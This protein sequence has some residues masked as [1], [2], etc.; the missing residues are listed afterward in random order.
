MISNQYD[1]AY[2]SYQEKHQW[3][4]FSF[5]KVAFSILFALLVARMID[6]T[7][8]QRVFLTSEGN[9]YSQKLASSQQDRLEIVDTNGQ[10]L[11]INVAAKTIWIDPAVIQWTDRQRKQVA[12]LLKI[13][14]E[15]LAQKSRQAGK[16]FV[17]LKRKVNPEVAKALTQLK[18]KG[19][20]ADNDNRRYYTS[21]YEFA[22]LLGRTGIEGSGLE[23]IEFGLNE[24]LAQEK[25]D[26]Y[27][28]VDRFGRMIMKSDAPLNGQNIALAI[29]ARF[30]KTAYEL[31]KDAVLAHEADY[32]SMV[33][34]NP[35]TGEVVAMA[36]FPT[37]NPNESTLAY[38]QNSNNRAVTDLF[39]PGSVIKPIILSAVMEHHPIDLEQ[40]INVEKGKWNLNGHLIKDVSVGH[41]QLSVKD[42]IKRSSNIG[43]SKLALSV[44]FESILNSLDRFGFGQ[45]LTN[46]Y[47]G[48][49]AGNLP[50]LS[51]Q[52]QIGV[53][54][55]SYGYGIAVNQLQLTH[56]YSIIANDGKD[57]GVHFLKQSHGINS[58][59]Q[60][61]SKEISEQVR[62]TLAAAAEH[63]G[64]AK[65]ASVPGIKIGGKTG[66]TIINQD[67]ANGYEALFAGIVPIDNPKWVISVMIHR[68]RVNGYYGGLVAA[69][70]FS[71]MVKKVFFMPE[72][73]KS[74][75]NSQL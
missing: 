44:P 29:D 30:Q 69:P 23:G 9:K 57:A 55:L 12:V 59:E 68:P 24:K 18:I 10:K 71:K 34:M 16:R 40:M 17:Y 28:E 43:M 5:M 13:S 6:L 46:I 8:Y 26:G 51:E 25:T 4:R 53:A 63:D 2:C 49:K 19:L 61:I 11:A 36:Q 35:K 54:G 39:E 37:V 20:H 58:Q 27:F 65:R 70:I 56:A 14:E 52:D 62:K 75:M 3:N 50:I 32:G 21:G 15:S 41:D 42:I 22:N 1:T 60:V 7:C 72:T 38:D 45:K 74:E 33:V 73:G 31:L 66:T 48:V 64:T 67:K 47:P